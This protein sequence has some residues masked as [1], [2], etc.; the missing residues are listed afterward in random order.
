MNHCDLMGVFGSCHYEQTG[1]A[2]HGSA[3]SVWGRTDH[4]TGS[5]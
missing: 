3:L 5:S 1:I 4:G 2:R